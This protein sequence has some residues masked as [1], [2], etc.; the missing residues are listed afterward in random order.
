MGSIGGLLGTSGGAAGTGFAGPAAS[1]ISDPTNMAQIQTAYTGNQN[2][3]KQQQDLLNALQAQNGIQNQNNA[4]N[5][6]QAIASGQ[7]PNPAQAQLAQATGQNIAAQSALA[8]GQRGSNANAGLIAR[9][10]AQQGANLQQQQIG[11]SAN[12]QANQALNAIGQAGNIANTQVGNQ[13]GQTN[14]NN[15]AQQ[16]EQ[17]AL[18]NAQAG[19]NSN[20]VSSQNNINSV[21][22]QLANTQLQGQQA[23]IGGAMN[24]A[25]SFLKA[26]GGE[27]SASPIKRYDEGGDVDSDSSISDSVTPTPSPANEFSQNPQQ[28]AQVAAP[29]SDSVPTFSS[30]AGSK[31]GGGLS[32]ILGLAA[33][34]AD[35]G[36]VEQPQMQS[37]PNQPKSKF[38]QF[39]KAISNPPPGADSDVNYG[40]PGANRL[41]KGVTALGQSLANLGKQSAPTPEPQAVAGGP[42]DQGGP[43]S[44]AIMAARGGKVPALVSPGE[45]YLDPK[46]VSEVKKGSNPMQIGEK[47]PGKPKVGGAKNSYAND[48]VRKNLDEG[49]IVIP[50]SVTKGPNPN[51]NAM[52]FVHATMAKNRQK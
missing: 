51:W 29:G 10:A 15:S 48:T 6:L 28:T 27:V 13:I 46:K 50:R 25:G 20:N 2:S 16:A 31:S 40:N 4:Y 22:G 42:S 52:K 18:F 38:A 41:N 17:A 3:L 37:S 49:G 14:A 44:D 36:E 35:G 45:V 1:S 24:A 12:L 26:E 11:Q 47:I 8:A 21:N 39:F 9:Q 32:G 19:V 5:Q 33:L 34:L 7:G 43:Q 30:S 23:M